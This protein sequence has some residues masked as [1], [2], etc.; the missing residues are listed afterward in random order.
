MTNYRADIDG[1]RAIAVMA[2]L[3][4][5]AGV[6][7]LSGGFVGVD[8]FF[9][10]SGF[11]ITSILTSQ[12]EAGKEH[13]LRNFYIRRVRR[14]LP[15]LV[16][17]I[18]FCYVVS[19][20]FLFDQEYIRFAESSLATVFFIP[21]LYF[22]GKTGYFEGFGDDTPL[23]HTWSL[24]VEEQ[25]YFIIP[26]IIVLLLRF[27]NRRVLLVSFILLLLMSFIVNITYIKHDPLLSFFFLPARMWEML[28]GSLLVFLL[29]FA[30]QNK[31]ISEL[32]GILGVILIFYAY[33]TL[34]KVSVF[35]GYN[36]II[37]VIGSCFIILSNTS[38]INMVGRLLSLRPLVFVGLLSYSL[39]LWHWPITVFVNMYFQHTNNVVLITLLSFVLATI[40]YFLIEHPIRKGEFFS[41]NKQLGGGMVFC[42]SLIVLFSGIVIYNEG[43]PS[44]LPERVT[45]FMNS[46]NNISFEF[47]RDE[48]LNCKG[49]RS[50]EQIRK[51]DV[52]KI[53]LQEVAASFV[54]LGDS[55]AGSWMPGIK[56]AAYERGVSGYRINQAGCRALYKVHDVQLPHCNKKMNAALEWVSTQDNIKT[57]ILIG[58]WKVPMTGF[59]YRSFNYY[60]RDKQSR[61]FDVAKN[62]DVFERGLNRTAELLH[63]K[64]V[65]VVGDVPEVKYEVQKIYS[66]SLLLSDKN[67]DWNINV[68]PS[69]I[70]ILLKEMIINSPFNN[71]NYISVEEIICPNS[72]CAL[73]KDDVAL[74]KDG[75]H[76]TPV[77]AVKN[78][79]VFHKIFKEALYKDRD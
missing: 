61:E 76:I 23:L 13:I 2:V 25:F 34:S 46:S 10:I 50:V 42:L 32:F 14:L 63:G 62:I 31:I 73:V 71:L 6:E 48:K 44:R 41:T 40:S 66:R 78:R 57:V 58:Y 4:Y 43:L 26:T 21:N 8:V 1:L 74:Y 79:A 22:W 49:R 70:E 59:G 28:A 55:H 12:A 54:V 7:T 53:G 68:E 11:L 16:I 45:S 64:R 37:P 33:F 20:F 67:S 47:A 60:L 24:G 5:H 18:L 27:F 36:A 39:Y 15:S 51:G 35:P 69:K 72:I 56:Q 29:R 3:F 65:L 17:V 19:Y 77:S 30:P 75:D 9:V 52:C 38:R